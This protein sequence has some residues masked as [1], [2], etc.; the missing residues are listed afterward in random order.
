[1][2]IR[3]A[4]DLAIV[5]GGNSTNWE[6]AALR[7]PFIY[8]PMKNHFEQAYISRNLARRGI[9]IKMSY[10]ETTPESLA[11]KAI[12]S[13]GTDVSYDPIP[14]DGAKKAARIINEYLR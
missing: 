6:L 5:Q 1:M 2:V 4:C 9:G 12:A 8:F 11:E 13:I 14:A 7:K 3:A 10:H